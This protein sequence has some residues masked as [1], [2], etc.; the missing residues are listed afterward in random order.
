MLVYQSDFLHNYRE[1]FVFGLAY[2]ASCCAIHELFNGYFC[3]VRFSYSAASA[4]L[5]N[6]REDYSLQQRRGAD[7]PLDVA[8]NLLSISIPAND[9]HH[10]ILQW[11]ITLR[12]LVVRA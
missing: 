6:S 12:P 11:I 8:H 7:D 1:T 10:S 9:P 2:L 5:K 4:E 3:S